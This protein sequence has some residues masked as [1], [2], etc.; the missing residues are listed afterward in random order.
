MVNF[1]LKSGPGNESKMGPTFT[2]YFTIWITLRSRFGPVSV[3]SV[4]FRSPWG[5]LPF[6]PRVTLLAPLWV[7]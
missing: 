2:I 1:R 6:Y 5:C 3:P 7:A 4:P